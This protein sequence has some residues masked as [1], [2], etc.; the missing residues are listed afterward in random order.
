MGRGHADRTF[1]R[2]R[3]K[4]PWELA[5]MQHFAVLGWAHALATD[6]KPGFGPARDYV[7]EFRNQTLDFIATNPPRF[8]VNWR[9]TMDI[10]IRA[11]NWIVAHD[12]FRAFGAVFDAPFSAALT[13]SLVDHG[14][15]IVWPFELYPEG[16]GN[17]YLADISGLCFIAAALPRSPETD[18]WLAF[19]IQEL[20]AETAHQFGADGA[21]FEGST[22]YHRLAAETGRLRQRVLLGLPPDKRAAIRDAAPSALRTQAGAPAA[23]RADLSGH[24]AF[25]ADRR[26]GPFSR[27]VTK[28]SGLVAQIGDNDSGRFLKLHPIFT[29][30]RRQRRVSFT[31]ISRVIAGSPKMPSISTRSRSITGR[32]SPPPRCSSTAP[33]LPNSPD[34]MA[35]CRGR[36]RA[37]PRAAGRRRR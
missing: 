17:H 31:P 11:A 33:I 28:P 13:A 1:A 32:S 36:R 23:T 9:C 8:G 3:V 30:A 19:A 15:H 26:D 7:A 37:R 14:R 25:L 24:R 16:H 5:R 34:R 35:R 2:R 4:V 12:L 18:A 22:S 29:R 6:G 27:A 10:A 20:Q 21:D